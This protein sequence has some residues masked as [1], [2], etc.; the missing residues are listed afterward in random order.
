MSYWITIFTSV[1]E[2]FRTLY[3]SLFMDFVCNISKNEHYPTYILLLTISKLGAIIF[4]N[5]RFV[6]V[7]IHHKSHTFLSCLVAFCTYTFK[8]LIGSLGNWL[9]LTK[10][11][12]S[13]GQNTFGMC[14]DNV[15]RFWCYLDIKL[16]ILTVSHNIWRFLF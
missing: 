6:G 11:Q 2:I 8:V 12:R 16:T 5:R 10:G 7:Q 4:S 3:F 9:L 14:S 13:M 1:Q 15:T